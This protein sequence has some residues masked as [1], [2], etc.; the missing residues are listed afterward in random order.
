MFYFYRQGEWSGSVN[1]W[2][3]TGIVNNTN[4]L[5][6]ARISSVHLHHQMLY[7]STLLLLLSKQNC[8]KICYCIKR[9]LFLTGSV[10]IHLHQNTKFVSPWR[11]LWQVLTPPILS[12]PWCPNFF[13]HNRTKPMSFLRIK[14]Y[15]ATCSFICCRVCLLLSSEQRWQHNGKD[16]NSPGWWFQDPVHKIQRIWVIMHEKQL[17]STWNLVEVLVSVNRFL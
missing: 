9:C 2:E 5:T 4:L 14:N 7:L 15:P 13:T 6:F 17:P 10:S 3:A 11:R 12:K 1:S 8:I 16:R